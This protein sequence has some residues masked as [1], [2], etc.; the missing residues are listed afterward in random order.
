MINFRFRHV[1]D[2]ELINSLCMLLLAQAKRYKKVNE[3]A[4]FCGYLVGSYYHCVYD[5]FNYLFKDLSYS[6]LLEPLED[7][8]DENSEITIKDS[9]YQDLYFENE[10]QQLGLNWILGRTATFP[11]NHLTKFER[12]IISL[13]DDKKM[14]YE[15]VGAQMGYH[16]DTIW[17]KRKQ[18]KDKLQN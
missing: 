17:S 1:T 11:F 4:N 18:I 13:Y 14:T 15:A 6:H 12:T 2:T 7:H 10:K 8:I 5:H 9:W 16:R 3:K